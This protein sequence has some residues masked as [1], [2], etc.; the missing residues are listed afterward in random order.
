MAARPDVIPELIKQVV[1][2]SLAQYSDRQLL[3]RFVERGEEDAFAAILDRHGPM[4]L[5]LCR[6]LLPD[7]HLADDVL[8]ATFLVLARKAR[9]IRQRDSLASWLHGVARRLARQARLAE[10][11]RSRREQHAAADRKEE[12]EDPGW[13]ELLRVLDEELGRLS[14]RHRLPLLLCYLEGQT[15]DEAAHQLGWSLSTLRRRLEEARELLKARMIRRGATLGAALFAGFLSP[16]AARASL[17]A[18]LRQ[19]VLATARSGVTGIAV[20][21]SIMALASGA[22]RMTTLTKIALWSIL[23]LTVGGVLAGIVVRPEQDALPRKQQPLAEKPE[24]DRDQPKEKLPAGAIARLGTSAFRHGRANVGWRSL[25]FTPDGKQLISLG[26]GWLRRW[27]VATGQAIVNLGDGWRDGTFDADLM[28][29]ADGKVACVCRTDE[30]KPAGSIQECITYDFETGKEQQKYLHDGIL[31]RRLRGRQ[32]LLLPDGKTVAEVAQHI[33]LWNITD[34]KLVKEFKLEQGGYTA[35]GFPPGGKTVIG[36]DDAHTIHVLDLKTGKELRSFGIA[37]VNGVSL[38]AVSPDD[39]RLATHSMSDG[40][41]RLWDLE[42]GTEERVLDFP[43][44]KGVGSMRFTPD[45]RTLIAGIRTDRSRSRDVVRT[46][47]VASGKPGRAWTDDP[48]IGFLTAISPDGKTLATMND[49]SVIRLWDMESGKEKRSQA[50]SPCAL[51]AVYFQSDAKTVLTVGDDFRLREWDAVTG[52]LLRITPTDVKVDR[53]RFSVGGVPRFSVGG[54]LLYVDKDR[55]V[56]R[57]VDR[58]TGK[59]EWP[60]VEGWRGVLSADGKRVAVALKE[61]KMRIFELRGDKTATLIQSWMPPEEKE[62]A[63]R[64]YPVPR[65]FTPDSQSLI[66]QGEIVSVRDIKTGKQRTSWSLR[67]NKVLEKPEID[68]QRDRRFRGELERIDAVAV[69]PDGNSIAFAVAK[70]RPSGFGGGRARVGLTRFMILETRTGKLL[71]QADVEDE[72][73][74]A[75]TFSPD[76]KLLA[77]GGTWTVRVWRIGTEK[78]LHHFEGHRGRINSLAFSPDGKRLASASEDSS[79]LI[80]DVKP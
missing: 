11:A 46:W 53:V 59:Q 79:V 34:G 12:G 74:R 56:M 7:A 64:P 1:S 48:T 68:D 55:D 51:T 8:Q 10:T 6:R 28:V 29:T 18:E 5:A 70:N 72:D 60:D 33:H 67:R 41:L 9:S 54:E 39:K 30:E 2:E 80:W 78:A 13:D 42:K 76:G 45:G 26:G 52:R 49:H 58:S 24:A 50:A 73:F 38:M 36:G 4:L 31:V 69:S 32:R 20:P 65:G 27:D 57:L 66:V 77:A 3:D 43:D 47:D 71:H 40:F 61:G 14:Q 23:L 19:A 16:S 63:A 37:N 25:A 35:M 17:T 75:L 44:D 21:A 15:Q 22:M 62:T